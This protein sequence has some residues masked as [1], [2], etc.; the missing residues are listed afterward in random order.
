M[1]VEFLQL[2]S[3]SINARKGIKTHG[4]VAW[5]NPGRVR[6]ESINA[7]KG[8]KTQNPAGQAMHRKSESIN[9]RKGIKTRLG[10]T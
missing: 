10:G 3:E 5:G 4:F 9:A 6:S 7:R 1:G 8:I 2:L